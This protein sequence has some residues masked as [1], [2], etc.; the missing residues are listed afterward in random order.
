LTELLFLFKDPDDHDPAVRPEL[1]AD[2]W[3]RISQILLG[4]I[5]GLPA[6]RPT[7]ARLDQN[8]RSGDGDGGMRYQE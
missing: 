6:L 4:E 7:A 5:L 8:A 3:T 2:V 1:P